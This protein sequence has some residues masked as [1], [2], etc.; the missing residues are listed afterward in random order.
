MGTGKQ[1]SR[2]RGAEPQ[3]AQEENLKGKK[4]TPIKADDVIEVKERIF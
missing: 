3:L 4:N 1:A 2:E